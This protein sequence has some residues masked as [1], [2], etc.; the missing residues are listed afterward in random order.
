MW[1]VRLA[2]RRP[3]TVAVG[4][5]LIFLLGALSLRSMLIDIF[6]VV[7]IPVVNVIWS[8]GGMSAEDME[9]RVVLIAE[10]SYSSTVSGITSVESQS[11]PGTGIIRLYFEPGTE[12]GAAIAQVSATSATLLRIFPP[13]FTAPVV[14]PYNA[15]NVP[16]VQLTLSSESMSESEIFDY[17]LQFLRVQ[18]FSV[19]GVSIP[20]PNGGRQRQINVEI[21][22]DKLTA[23]GLS[24]QDVVSALQL[25]DTILP[26]GSARLG[27]RDYD[28]SLNSIPLKVEEFNALPIKIVNNALVT[29]GDVA[30][31]SDGGAI[32]SNLVRIN[33]RRSAFVNIMKKTDAS[34]LDVINSV[35]ALLPKIRATA[36][37]GL[38]IK[39]DYDQ[40]VFVK[41]AIFNVVL[42]ALVAT[43]LVS[44]M[45][46]LFLGSWR[47]TIVVCTSIPLAILCSIIG[48][49]LTGNSINIMTL[50]GLSLAVGM[51]VDDATVEVENIHR[52]LDLGTPLVPS[53][54][55]SAH[56]VALPAIMAT[57]AICIVFFPVGLLTGPARF[58]FTPMA[59]AVVFAMLASYLLS[60]TLVPQ[61]SRALMANEHL[62]HQNRFMR[63]FD[64]V[65]SAYERALDAVLHQRALVLWVAL[66]LV[67]ITGVLSLFVGL[68]FFPQT[69]TGLMKL[70]FRAPPGTRL[71]NTEALVAKIEDRIRAIIPERDLQTITAE[72]GLPIFYNL[73]FSRT[74]SMS[75]QDADVTIGLKDGH[76]PTEKYVKAL[77]EDLNRN[78]PG[79]LIYF[80]PADIISQVLNFGL[81][82]P[83]DIQ[84]EGN[85]TD[86]TLGLAKKLK[87]E[88]S[89]IPGVVDVAIKQAFDAPVLHIEVDRTRA[90]RLGVNQRDITNSVLISLSSNGSVAPVYYL[91]PQNNVNYTVSTRS[92]LR[93]LNTIDDVLA[94]P[95]SSNTINLTPQLVTPSLTDV[96][97][98]DTQRLGNMAKVST[99]VQAYGIRHRN[100]QRYIDMSAGIE[101]RD[102]GSVVSDIQEKIDALGKLPPGVSITVRGQNE[103]MKESFT[104]LGL[105]IILALILVYLL[106]VVLFQSWLDP[107]IVLVAVPGAFVGI[108]WMM[109]LTGTTFNVESLMGSIMAIGIAASNSILLVS[110]AND[111]RVDHGFSSIEAALHAGKTRLR[112]VLMTALAM[113]LGMLPSA[114]NLGEGGEQ[115]APLGR[116]VI[117]GLLIAT[118]VTLF[119]VPVIYSLLRKELPS[120]HLLDQRLDQEEAQRTH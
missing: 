67:I 18:L 68:D 86:F 83:I 75:A 54:L 80:Q 65:Q 84:F 95:V 85:K 27:S 17:A 46:L 37:K 5:L 100:V 24:P 55:K 56:Q 7:D 44:L 105:G 11:I 4:A 21:D 79:S 119:I 59:L 50:G 82:A 61:L 96:P 22:K 43:L 87:D 19:P 107:F 25:S 63:A 38:D 45:L 116:A 106:M 108:V 88:I 102:L 13:G 115:I 73:A 35:K 103:V 109:A 57:L 90:A 93:D 62:N 101:G 53:I 58:L 20:A 92:P 36:P 3:Y 72:V 15:A 34:T 12:I 113:V 78:L 69:D 114:L 97:N 117:G 91:N 31:A 64:K 112:P 60:R 104:K 98:P 48:L 99:A 6:P 110:F 42:E 14:M 94:L 33:G 16:V 9:R 47:S 23:R 32:Q 49:K 1:I 30:N 118:V 10:R 81:S 77:R 2:L 29:I 8:Y 70:H 111:A 89:L 52:N 120:K 76:A 26:A 74:D 28:I 71:E 39:L 40:S 51:L 66:I 41:A